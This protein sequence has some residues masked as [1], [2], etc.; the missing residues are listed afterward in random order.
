[1]AIIDCEANRLTQLVDQLLDLTALE[2][3]ESRFCIEEFDLLAA[4]DETVGAFRR[5][6]GRGRSIATEYDCD[7]GAY[8]G[9]R[10]RLQQLLE[11]LLD[12]AAKFTPP[13]SPI[14]I[15]L[16]S[17]DTG[18]ELRVADRGPGVPSAVDQRRIFDRFVQGGDLLTEKPAGVG[19]GLAI[20]AEIAAAHGGRLSYRDRDGGGAEFVLTLPTGSARLEVETA[21]W[22]GA[23]GGAYCSQPTDRP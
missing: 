1:M 21:P 17:T 11:Q 6:A 23:V 2:A 12:N 9:D 19:L 18:I 3:G 7:V 22:V 10:S 15:H 8:L 5:G 16:E 13:D 14:S 20:G 4:V